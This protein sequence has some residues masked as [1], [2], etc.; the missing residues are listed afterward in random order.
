MRDPANP[1]H[2]PGRVTSY[3]LIV[4]SREL[5]LSDGLSL[6]R[7]F[8]SKPISYRSPAAQLALPLENVFIVS[9]QEF[10]RLMGVAK[11]GGVDVGELLAKAASDNR[12]P[13]TA[14]LFLSQHY[15]VTRL[16]RPHEIMTAMQD[17]YQRIARALGI[18]EASLEA[19][20]ADKGE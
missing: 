8:P 6:Q 3:A 13:H 11:N 7:L 12:N 2:D 14:K 4:T 19:A 20:L 1:F 5:N 18:T 10:D 15:A 16:E 9:A 17:S